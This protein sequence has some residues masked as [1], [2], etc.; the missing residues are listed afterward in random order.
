V[1]ITVK[2]YEN[3]RSRLSTSWGRVGHIWTDFSKSSLMD[4]TFLLGLL[5]IFY[6][7]KVVFIIPI[8]SLQS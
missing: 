6:V 7:G 4:G 2:G 1:V 3:L 5:T 8:F